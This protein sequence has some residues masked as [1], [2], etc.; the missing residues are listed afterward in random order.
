MRYLA[1][2]DR[3]RALKSG[4][5]SG[6]SFMNRSNTSFV[7]VNKRQSVTAETWAVVVFVGSSSEISPMPVTG[8]VCVVL[9]F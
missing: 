1:N 2:L 7:N 6:T 5:I 9:A 3:A 8:Y 4:T